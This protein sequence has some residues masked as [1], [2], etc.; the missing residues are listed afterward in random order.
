[1]DRHGDSAMNH[2]D[3]ERFL[4]Y[5]MVMEWDFKHHQASIVELYEVVSVKDL[6]YLIHSL[7]G[8][9]I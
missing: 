5:F 7:V 4:R 2:G 9:L 6:D 8:W 3:C 1:M